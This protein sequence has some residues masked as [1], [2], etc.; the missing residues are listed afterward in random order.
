M[1][2]YLVEK[3]CV[4]GRAA[5]SLSP[6][7]LCP[8]PHHSQWAREKWSIQNTLKLKAEKVKYL[9][10]PT[11]ISYTQFPWIWSR[12]Y[13]RPVG[14]VIRSRELP[15]WVHHGRVL[16]PC[17]ML[18]KIASCRCVW[19]YFK[20][21]EFEVKF[22]HIFRS[23]VVHSTRYNKHINCNSRLNIC[24]P[25][26][27]PLPPSSPPGLVFVK[28]YDASTT[29]TTLFLL[30]VNCS[31]WVIKVGFF[32]E[33]ER[34]SINFINTFY[35]VLFYFCFMQ[36]VFFGS[37]HLLCFSTLRRRLSTFR[38]YT[39][40]KYRRGKFLLPCCLD[41]DFL[42]LILGDVF[43]ELRGR[44][45]DFVVRK[46]FGGGGGERCQKGVE[47]VHELILCDVNT[48]SY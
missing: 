10:V 20:I 34:K 21:E 45:S 5:S 37:S 12:M 23:R 36:S 18:A 30:P 9:C 40:V 2:C 24:P 27:C 6:I 14:H 4:Y 47:C 8:H 44:C 48:S 7:S 28:L 38:L 33:Y 42:L 17:P 31:M 29:T 19:I 15:S 25:F 16:Q 13:G 22:F 39:F 35:S 3:M 32:S 1:L 46:C 26:H 41:S 11:Y 43:C